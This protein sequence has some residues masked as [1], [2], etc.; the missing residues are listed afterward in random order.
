MSASKSGEEKRER[1]RKRVSSSVPFFSLR[2]VPF[3]A[4]SLC[5]LIYPPHYFSLS[6]MVRLR[7]CRVASWSKSN[8]RLERQ[9][10]LANARTA[11]TK[12]RN[13]PSGTH[14]HMKVNRSKTQ[15]SLSF[16]LFF[17]LILKFGASFLKEESFS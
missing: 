10:A 3:A 6:S 15:Y 8:V 14:K 5:L 1:T 16:F 13:S 9:R 12:M 11:T 2:D 7:R 4:S 17:A